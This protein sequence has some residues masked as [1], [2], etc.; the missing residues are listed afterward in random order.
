MFFRRRPPRKIA[1]RIGWQTG[2]PRSPIT[3]H[4]SLITDHRSPITDH[5]SPITDHRSPITDHRSPITDHRSPITN[6]RPLRYPLGLGGMENARL[7]TANAASLT[8]SLIVG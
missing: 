3:D 2:W 6:H 1:L 4:Q 8:A 5:R 7:S